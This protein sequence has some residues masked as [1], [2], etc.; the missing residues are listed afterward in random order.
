VNAD[1]EALRERV[2]GAHPEAHAA[3]Q[4]LALTDA[5]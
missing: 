4:A 2:V 1:Y 3:G 5:W